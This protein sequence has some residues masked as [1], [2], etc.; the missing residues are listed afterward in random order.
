MKVKTSE[1]VG[2]PLNWAVA[3]S[4]NYDDQ[5]RVFL[6]ELRDYGRTQVHDDEWTYYAPSTD[7]AQGGRIAECNDIGFLPTEKH[8][9]GQAKAFV[10]T[11]SQHDLCLE[12]ACSHTCF[13]P[14][15]LIAVCRC[16][17]ASKLGD[18]VDI[19]DDFLR[20]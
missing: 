7:W 16:F 14:T 12:D 9:G 5:L 19:P 3:K 17:V 6:D 20:R 1:L 8:R 13:G 2:L 10:Y 11:P 18:E 4:E 15:P